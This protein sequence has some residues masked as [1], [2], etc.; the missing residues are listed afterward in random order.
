MPVPDIAAA[1]VTAPA[2][3]RAAAA[4]PAS[5]ERDGPGQETR[6]S[7]PGRGSRAVADSPALHEGH[8]RSPVAGRH[9]RIGLRRAPGTERS[10][11]T[12]SHRAEDP[13]GPRRTRPGHRRSPRSD[14]HPRVG[15]RL[16][17]AAQR[18]EHVRGSRPRSPA[19]RRRAEGRPRSR[20]QPIGVVHR[21]EPAPDLDLAAVAR[22]QS[23][24]RTWAPPARTGS[25]RYWSAGQPQAGRGPAPRRGRPAG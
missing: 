7:P 18:L 2:S 19:A 9:D 1:P 5:R 11:R 17:G 3:P 24:W 6:P 13:V 23:T 16:D 8:R 12:T 14:H 25:G 10:T 4:P 21:A 20:H 15:R 22:P